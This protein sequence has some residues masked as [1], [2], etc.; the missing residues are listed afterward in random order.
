MN[1]HAKQCRLNY[2][3]PKGGCRS[4]PRKER[5]QQKAK[6]KQKPIQQTT[7]TETMIT[8][9]QLIVPPVPSN[10]WRK[11]EESVME[12]GLFLT[13][14]WNHYLEKKLSIIDDNQDTVI[15]DTSWQNKHLS[16]LSVGEQTCIW[17]KNSLQ[18]QAFNCKKMFKKQERKKQE[19][20]KQDDDEKKEKEYKNYTDLYQSI[21]RMLNV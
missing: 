5:K 21:R 12:L 14:H 15:T 13:T 6:E 10:S 16:K 1:K 7:M 11:P 2:T 3:D 4:P 18:S 19:R 9:E 20:K 8:K 17:D